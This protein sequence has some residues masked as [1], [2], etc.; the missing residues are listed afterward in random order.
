MK[1][2]TKFSIN[3][4]VCYMKDNKV[5]V[6]TVKCISINISLINYNDFKIDTMY[7]IDSSDLSKKV[8]ED[9]LFESK[10]ELLNSL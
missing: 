8:T 7:H 9:K 3:D 1:I 2:E 6:S 4:T 10:Q 5:K